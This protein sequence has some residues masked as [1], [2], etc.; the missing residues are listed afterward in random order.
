MSAS[1]RQGTDSE[2][3]APGQP[4]A[5]LKLNLGAGKTYIPG[6]VN[7]DIDPKA[8]VVL[9][10][11]SDPLPFPD[12]SVDEVVS[13]HTLEH[14][15]DYLFA[16]GEIY[17]V[18]RHDGELLLSLPYVTL[19]EHHQVN[20]YHL[21]NFSER[22]F[23]FFEPQVLKGSAAEE[24]ETTFRRTFVRYR[25]NGYFGLLPRP[26]RVWARRHLLNVVVQFDIGLVAIKDRNA[27]VDLGPA[28]A[29]A[30]EA[31]LDE[32]RRARRRYEEPAAAAGASAPRSRTR[33]VRRG[34]AE[35]RAALRRRWEI[36]YE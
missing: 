14:V 36:R 5:P 22:S 33:R 17:R 20:P 29:K 7:I 10:L 6:F 8:E 2:E 12:D 18:M 19:T 11:G 13:R 9:D 31:R 3:T 4:P 25:Y 28:R 32:L 16:I 34:L 15:G 1:P 21:H 35:R 27:P 24:S 23:D 26:M 30:M